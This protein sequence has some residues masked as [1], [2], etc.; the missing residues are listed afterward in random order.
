DAALKG[1]LAIVKALIEAG[2]TGDA[3]QGGGETALGLAAAAGHLDVVRLLV[4]DGA[5]PNVHDAD[6]QTALFQALDH[7]HDAIADFLRP[8]SSPETLEQARR[9]LDA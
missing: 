2:A 3:R 9:L 5:D 6:G 7:R 4:E 8:L 1:H